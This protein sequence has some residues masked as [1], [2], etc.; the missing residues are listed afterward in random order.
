MIEEYFKKLRFYNKHHLGLGDI[1]LTIGQ[2]EE[3]IEMFNDK[4]GQ[5]EPLV[6]PKIA[7]ITPEEFLE[8]LEFYNEDMPINYLDKN[9]KEDMW[10]EEQLK[11]LL[12]K[13]FEINS[14]FSV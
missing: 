10:T 11:W 7:G 8:N 12:N 3:I 2:Q 13:Y 1:R 9:N 5:I 4:V 6:I 14:N